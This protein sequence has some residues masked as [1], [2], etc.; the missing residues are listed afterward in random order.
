MNCQQKK[1]VEKIAVALISVCG[2]T[3]INVGSA[4]AIANKEYQPGYDTVRCVKYDKYNE[5]IIIKNLSNDECN[6][7]QSLGRLKNGSFWVNAG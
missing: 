6:Y 7:R 3:A 1:T 5:V 4:F 2:I